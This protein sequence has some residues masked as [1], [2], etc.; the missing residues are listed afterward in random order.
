MNIVT[1][2]ASMI[3]YSFSEHSFFVRALQN[4]Y[5]AK[6]RDPIIFRMKPNKQRTCK[7]HEFGSMKHSLPDA[8][9]ESILANEVSN[10]YPI[11]LT[12]F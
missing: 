8:L 11:Q 10:H 5:I 4:L 12:N 7:K 6:T 2:L 9:D 3:I 1:T